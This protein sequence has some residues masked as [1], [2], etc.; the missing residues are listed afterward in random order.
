MAIPLCSATIL[1]L[2]GGCDAE[3]DS[4]GSI[5]RALQALGPAA[6][7]PVENREAIGVALMSRHLGGRLEPELPDSGDCVEARR[8][9]VELVRTVEA[10]GR[11]V[12]LRA[13][14]LDLNF[15]APVGVPVRRDVLALN[16]HSSPVVQANVE[17]GLAVAVD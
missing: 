9:D 7:N 16:E 13:R 5:E 8:N 2:T 15:R 14:L 17:V 10:T 3:G 12:F 11:I 6:I 1:S 4:P